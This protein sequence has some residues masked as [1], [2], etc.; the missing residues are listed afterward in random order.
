[1]KRFHYA[2][3]PALAALLC[4]SVALIHG[5]ISNS[6]SSDV[7]SVKTAVS[8]N[9]DA[10]ALREIKDEYPPK[11]GFGSEEDSSLDDADDTVTVKSEELE[12]ATDQTTTDNEASD[13]QLLSDDRNCTVTATVPSDAQLSEDTDLH[14]ERIMS[15]TKEYSD[16]RDEVVE[17]LEGMSADASQD[18]M[19]I[20]S[21]LLFDISLTED[22]EEVEPTAPVSVEMSLKLKNKELIGLDNA[23]VVH[24]D[25]EHGAELLEH[26]SVESDGKGNVV[27]NFETDSFSV[28]AIV[29]TSIEKNILASDGKNYKV[30]VTAGADSG[31]PAGA[32][33]EVN[34]I[35]DTSDE[36]K[37]YVSKTERVL[38]DTEQVTFARFFDISIMADGKEIQPTA[39]VEVKIELADELTEDVRAVHFTHQKDKEKTELLDTELAQSE[40]LKDAVKFETDGFSVYGVVLTELFTE[41]IL[42][43]SNDAYTVKVT[44][45]PE[46]KIPEGSTLQVKSLEEGTEAYEYARNAVLADRKEKGDLTDA[47]SLNLA[48]LDI[49]ILGPDGKELE[50]AAAVTVDFK[51]KELPGVEDL[52]QVEKTL[53]IQHHVEVKDGVVV[54]T[55]FDGGSDASFQM[56]TDEKV[57]AEGTA[58]DPNSVNEE[59]FRTSGSMG[60][61]GLNIEF[62]ATVF[63]TF[64]ISWNNHYGHNVEVHYVDTDGNE[65]D[66]RNSTFQTTLTGNSTTPAYLIYD[67]DGYEYD[68]TYRKYY[69]NNRW[70]TQD[71][72]PE[73]ARNKNGWTYT[74][75]SKDFWG[76][77]DWRNLSSSDASKKDEIYVVYKEKADIAQGG[78]PTVKQSGNVDPP[79]APRINKE[80]TPNGDDT[81]TLALSLISDTAKLEVEKLADVIVVFDVSKSMTDNNLGKITRLQAAKNAVNTLA[82]QLAQ[83]KNS[84]GQPLVRMSLIQFSTKASP[85]ISEM[86]DLTDSG[87]TSFKNK[88]NKLSA[89]GGTNW[90]HALQLANEQSGLDSGRATFVIFVTDGDPT[91]RN[92]RMNVTDLE[93]QGET[94][95][96]AWNNYGQ[97]SPNPFYLSDDVYGPADND[98]TGKCY[99]AAVLQGTAIRA[100]GKNLY[101]IGISN[102]VQKVSDFNTAV[103]GNGAYLTEDQEALQEAFA[104]IESEISGETGWGNIQMTDGITKLT[105]TVQKTGLINVGGDFSYYIAPAPSNWASMTEAE[106]NAYKPKDTDFVSWDPEAAGAALA[107]Y[108]AT[109]GAVEWN[110]GSTFMPEPGVTYQ[111]RF[112]VWPS[113]E[114]YD[115]IAKLNN[116]TILYEPVEGDNRESLTEAVRKQII[117]NGNTYTL[118]TN[119]PNAKTTYQSA[120]RTGKT[121][122]A[123]GETKTLMFPTVEDLNLSVDKM[124]VKKEWVNDLD[125]RWK[126]EVPLKLTDG[127][128]NLYRSFM[129]NDE[130]NYTM[131]DNFISCGLAKVENNE[132][133]IY[134]QGHDFML[135]E[136]E[137]YGYYWELDSQIY[138]PMIIDAQ[139]TMLVKEDAPSGMGDKTYYVEQGT[140]Y[141][142]IGEGTY[143]AISTGNAAATITATNIRRSNL[144][145]TK[146]VVD[147]KDKPVIS[148][149]PFTF[150]ITVND[151]QDAEVWF[152]VQTDANDTSTVVKKLSTNATAEVKN[153]EKTGYYHAN[154]GSPITVSIQPGWNLRFTNLPNG[155]TYTITESVKEGYTFKSA[156]VDH[157]GTFAIQ[158][159]TTGTGVIKAPNTQYTVTYTNQSKLP[160]VGIVKVVAGNTET[161]LNGATFTLYAIDKNGSETEVGKYTTSGMAKDETELGYVDIGVLSIGTYRL[162]ETEAPRGFMK[163][164]DIKFF[165]KADSGNNISVKNSDDEPY[166][167]REDGVYVIPVE[168]PRI[169][170]LPSA[171][172][173]GTY[174]FTIIGVAILTTALLLLSGD[175]RIIMWRK[176]KNKE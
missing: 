139:L 143:K 134:E 79:V 19:D 9:R 69:N 142:K 112:K 130:N 5:N 43:G 81:N 95:D 131:K 57:A 64:T 13:L 39:P 51:I 73:L 90:D 153:G 38:E 118:K 42:P 116:G 126:S 93:L 147:E 86:T 124:T 97:L 37:T 74:D 55:V 169:Y 40:S 162:V 104:K 14:V 78:T 83:K 21:L 56:E 31:I 36:Y 85:V 138:R 155:T 61:D 107:N 26:H 44:A 30:T 23:I 7:T 176:L 164:P 80:S 168:D 159:G 16:Y 33:L 28:F 119:E 89:S 137:E 114:A 34:E 145:L 50:P 109:T 45:P 70:K 128:G 140:T 66:V 20:G 106:K 98:K 117:K 68:H 105:N 25:K 8:D 127:D 163:A 48:A 32:E 148:S 22:G 173:P 49:S 101:T 136:P 141:Y 103:G 170:D 87:L 96:G 2:A 76:N 161:K 99:D 53:E 41:V 172:G 72:L 18:K 10:E 121:V 123:S 35:L 71:V 166:L 115:Y 59:G 65:L 3:I 1:M 62:E 100:A 158:N 63:S 88:V 82:E 29:G 110:M 156:A 111:V 52:K 160:K 11:A 132:L 154:S 122:T 149:D 60:A 175:K 75:G 12:S 144:N 151:T 91:F 92:S 125:S 77:Y 165:V 120:T 171:G 157:E 47:G 46:A 27:A 129:L 174:Q 113:Q 146:K 150:A 102:S 67:I 4:L 133:V 24:F 17:V 6:A 54:E 58:V 152:S 108:N 15:N 167:Q 84:A 135:T 94:N